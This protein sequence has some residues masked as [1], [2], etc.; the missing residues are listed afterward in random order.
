MIIEIPQCS[1][2]IN[3]YWGDLTW[4]DP[5]KIVQSSIVLY[6]KA[7]GFTGKAA[8]SNH[9]EAIVYSG[10][11]Y[12][13][14]FN[15]KFPYATWTK[16]SVGEILRG[17]EGDKPRHSI[18]KCDWLDYQGD[19]T[20]FK[21][22]HRAYRDYFNS[23]IPQLPWYKRLFT[24][25]YDVPELLGHPVWAIQNGVFDKT[26]PLKY[27]DLPWGNNTC[28][29]AASKGVDSGNFALNKPTNFL[30]EGCHPERRFPAMAFKE[31]HLI[32]LAK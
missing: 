30:F 2:K 13:Y 20:N 27:F 19:Y 16:Y 21:I 11:N 29:G 8:R 1:I 14:T 9:A 18:L 32:D 23:Q 3:H 28:F 6:N 24:G 26:D 5:K 22:Y 12:I 7:K 25:F 15:Q 17:M 4:R 31:E 10:K